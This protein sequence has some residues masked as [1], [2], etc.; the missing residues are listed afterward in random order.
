[1]LHAARQLP[2]W[3]TFNVGQRSMGILIS[4][5]LVVGI[6]ACVLAF[7]WWLSPPET[8]GMSFGIFAGSGIAAFILAFVYLG[9]N[10]GGHISEIAQGFALMI[11]GASWLFLSIAIWTGYHAIRVYGK[12]TSEFKIEVHQPPNKSV[13]PTPGSFTPRAPSSTSR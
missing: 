10:G 3:L 7:L 8:K 4:I 2:S 5:A 11:G 13:Q 9:K 6:P 1:M 12:K